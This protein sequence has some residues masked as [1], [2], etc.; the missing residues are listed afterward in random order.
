MDTFIFSKKEIINAILNLNEAWLNKDYTAAENMLSE[1]FELKI[2]KKKSSINRSNKLFKKNSINKLLNELVVKRFD[3]M[4]YKIFTV[5][6]KIIV[7][8]IFILEAVKNNQRFF[9]NGKESFTMHNEFNGLK[10]DRRIVT[11]YLNNSASKKE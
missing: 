6:N 10:F 11:V 2:R 1:K 4:E 5:K 7:T 8:D 9:L 3:Q